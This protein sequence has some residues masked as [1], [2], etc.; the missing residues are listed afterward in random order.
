[1]KPNIEADNKR[2]TQNNPCVVELENG[3]TAL[4]HDYYNDTC[5][6]CGDKLG[7]TNIEEQ[8]ELESLVSEFRHK[9][10]GANVS[11]AHKLGIPSS[12]IDAMLEDF[13]TYAN[14]VAEEKVREERERIIE[15]LSK[16]KSPVYPV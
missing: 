9:W 8:T 13:T 6:H 16:L 1:M 4:C 15:A 12:I 14:T 3:N 10:E 7:K 5:I 11:P 2:Q